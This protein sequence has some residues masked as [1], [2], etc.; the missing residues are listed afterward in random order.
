MIT[1]VKMEVTPDLSKR[2]QEIVFANGGDWV[3]SRKKTIQFT[4]KKRLCIENDKDLFY[5]EDETQRYFNEHPFKEISAYDFISSQGQQE[6]LPKYDEEALFSDDK[7]DWHKRKFKVYIPNNTYSSFLTSI[8]TYNYCKKIPKKTLSF[9]QFLKDNDAYD[10]YM[11]NIQIENQRWE[12]IIEYIEL[13]DLKKQN[14]SNWFFN[15]FNWVYQ[16]EDSNY[17]DKLNKKWLKLIHDYKKKQ[18][19]WGK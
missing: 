12:D 19:V 6:W 16:K 9:I 10:K 14:P 11:H 18:I 1:E 7:K 5:L 17:W 13:E 8:S 15:A 3:G 2:I 4:D